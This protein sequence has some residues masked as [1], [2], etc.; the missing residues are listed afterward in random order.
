M[1]KI[2]VKNLKVLITSVVLLTTSGCLFSPD[3]PFS[4]S[5]TGS[6][7]P[8][9]DPS[10]WRVAHVPSEKIIDV[11]NDQDYWREELNRL[12]ADEKKSR[13]QCGEIINRREHHL[14][15]VSFYGK[16]KSEVEERS[17]E[18]IDSKEIDYAKSFLEKGEAWRLFNE[19]KLYG[20]AQREHYWKICDALEGRV[21][22]KKCYARRDFS[23]K[24]S[25]TR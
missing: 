2:F 25:E 18:L 15:W 16:K 1:K 5:E 6:S 7:V 12:F 3:R 11:K 20:D 21:S 10:K 4:A 24:I 14:C 13:N 9:E 23:Q 17:R 19:S 8:I 22:Q